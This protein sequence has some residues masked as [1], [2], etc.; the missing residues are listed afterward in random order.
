MHII[1]RRRDFKF[2]EGRATI[3]LTGGAILV[4]NHAMYA[5]SAHRSM[6]NYRDLWNNGIYILTALRNSEEVLE[7]ME[8][9]RCLATAYVGSTGLYEL[10]FSNVTI[11]SIGANLHS[12][13]KTSQE[14]ASFVFTITLPLKT[15]LWHSRMGYP[16]TTMFHKML[17]IPSRHD[18]CQNVCQNDA[19]KVEVCIAC[20]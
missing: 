4:N 20:A 1:A 12:G 6:I 19:K 8:G 18:V 15:R 3:V 13:L 2:H 10:P 9:L 14:L 16:G 17:P 5:S 7:L 11:G